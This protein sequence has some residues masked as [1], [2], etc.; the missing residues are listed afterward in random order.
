MY[1]FLV[2]D[3]ERGHTFAV[4]AGTDQVYLEAL[5][6]EGWALN[7]IFITHHHDDH[8]S[9][10]GVLKDATG[11]RVLGPQNIIGVDEV[12]GEGPL[13]DLGIQVLATP[14]HTL[15]ML[16][17]HVPAAGAVF[18]GDTLFTLGCGR[19]FEGTPEMM[20]TSLAKLRALPP[21]TQVFGAHEW[22]LEN[23][24]FALTQFGEHPPLLARAD[25]V[26]AARAKGA[27][28]V[29]SLLGDE[30]ATNPF[31]LAKDAQEFSRIR[32]A[33]DAF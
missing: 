16:N 1:G 21:E 5:D 6:K 12:I 25:V 2:H 30:L 26:R 3:A 24:A 7:T 14:G 20:F 4:D 10:I 27:P 19:L 22:A 32:A 15:D 17:Y 13:P 18:T 23:L 31:L 11:A 29:P 28:M 8:V 9:H 33:K